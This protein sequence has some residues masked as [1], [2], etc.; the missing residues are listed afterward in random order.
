MKVEVQS[1]RVLRMACRITASLRRG[2]WSETTL[3]RQHT[4]ICNYSHRKSHDI[5]TTSCT[6]RRVQSPGQLEEFKRLAVAY[7]DWLS[8]DLDFQGVDDEL[9][10][11]PGVYAESNNGVLLLAS[12]PGEQ[13]VTVGTAAIRPLAGKQREGIDQVNSIKVDDICELKRVFV[14]PEYQ[15]NGVGRQLVLE[16]MSH[17]RRLGYKA[18]VL[19][20]LKR[21]E[22]ANR[23]YYSLGFENCIDY[24]HCP[25]DGPSHFYI[26][27]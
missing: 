26:N 3:H 6:I 27:L 9:T 10:T 16:A 17:A 20:T 7:L 19:D 13:E 21:L 18:M 22:A 5:M 24:S 25:L 12:I 2:T 8:E 4:T 1:I 14:D 23:M 15:K 11:L